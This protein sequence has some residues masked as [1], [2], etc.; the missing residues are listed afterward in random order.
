MRL[1]ETSEERGEEGDVD[2]APGI[3][4]HRTGGQE[5]EGGSQG[6]RSVIEVAYGVPGHRRWVQISGAVLATGGADSRGAFFSTGWKRFW[7]RML[8]DENGLLNLDGAL[9]PDRCGG[10]HPDSLDVVRRQGGGYTR[11]SNHSA[12]RGTIEPAD[13]S[14]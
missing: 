3:L 14:Q 13:G 1:V 6:G 2:G 5:V 7:L 8:D 9:D 4:E 12:L 10:S 11:D